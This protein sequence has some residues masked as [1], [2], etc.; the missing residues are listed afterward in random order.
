M[1]LTKTFCALVSSLT[2]AASAQVVNQTPAPPVETPT[3][4]KDQLRD[5]VRRALG[6]QEEA[7]PLSTLPPLTNT[8]ITYAAP[9]SPAG[10][11]NTNRTVASLSLQDA[12]QLAL[13]HNRDLQVERYN[14]IISEYDRRA[15]YSYYD[16]TFTSGLSRNNTVR[17]GGGF[18]PQTGAQFPATRT[19][20]DHID[21][22]IGGILPTGMR[23]DIGQNLNRIDAR[24]P[25]LIG[26]NQ[27]GAIFGSDR[28]VTYDS[29]AAITVS[30]PL[31]RNFWIDAPRLQ[32]KLARRNVR[33]SELVLE[34]EIMRIV[35]LVEQAYYELI[36]ARETVR[37][38]EA[39][40]AVKTQFFDENRRRVEVG[41]LAPLEEKLAQSELALAET[42]LIIARNDAVSAEARLK[43]LIHDDFANQ[44]NSDVQLTDKLIAVPIGVDLYES[45]RLAMERRPDLQARRLNLEK[46]QLQLKYDFNQLFPQLDVFASYGVNGLDQNVGGAFSDLA[47][48]SFEQERYGLAL[49]FPLTMQ[50]PRN[51][52]KASKNAKAQA[53]VDLKRLEE[54]IVEEV[55]FTV[56]QLRM[57]WAVIPLTRERTAYQQAALEAEQKKLIFGK[58]TSYN[59][60][61]IATDLTSARLNEIIAVK[62]YNQ[63]LA[64]LAYRNGST[65]ERQRIDRPVR[66]NQ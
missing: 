60:L 58:S 45:F 61:Q 28:S 52:Y 8:T 16:P 6:T 7:Y 48:R 54:T 2:V 33:I 5:A 12:I 35:T 25:S 63:S 37:V 31:L 10:G 13:V 47:N 21:A 39:D 41:T 65:L 11:F 44:L 43:A 23:Y 49:S 38:R 22:G 27:F 30:Q 29:D 24:R 59:V 18:N 62:N 15:L 56:R 1:R 20:T 64:E 9:R 19:E 34:R 36:G 51:N 50:G 26:T 55:D 4:S 32:I 3:D 14:P 42:A 66:P 57:Q 40:V 46:Q 17:E 53:I